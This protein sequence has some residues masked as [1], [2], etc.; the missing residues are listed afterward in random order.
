[1]SGK[2]PNFIQNSKLAIRIYRFE[3]SAQRIAFLESENAK[4]QKKLQDCE[5]AL[6]IANHE[7]EKA[8]KQARDALARIK[9]LENEVQAAGQRAAELEMALKEAEQKI[10][11]LSEKIR[12]YQGKLNETI[13]TNEMVC[14]LSQ[15]TDSSPF[16]LCSVECLVA[17]HETKDSVLSGAFCST[18]G[19]VKWKH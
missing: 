2:F 19:G 12:S 4:L 6:D 1:L 15:K 8:N 3:N 17:S 10:P 9:D 7:T 5:E 14:L 16:N 18:S 11:A 13:Q